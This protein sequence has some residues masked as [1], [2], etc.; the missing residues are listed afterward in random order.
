MIAG[1][2]EPTRGEVVANGVVMP[3]L[4]LGAGFHPELTGYENVFLQG[5]VLGLPRDEIRRKLGEIVAFA[6]LGD[7]M[8]TPVKYYSSGMFAR[9]A[10]SVAIHCDPE[11]LLVDEILAVGDADFQDKSFHK[12]L[13]FVGTGRTLIVVSHSLMALKEICDE[14]IWLEEGA[15]RKAGP[16]RDVIDAY[17]DWSYDRAQPFLAGKRAEQTVERPVPPPVAACRIVELRVFDDTGARSEQV[18]SRSPCTIEIDCD[19]DGEVADVGCRIVFRA[20]KDTGIAEMDSFA[21]DETFVLPRGR[22]TLRVA[23]DSLAV[24]QGTYDLEGV[25]FHGPAGCA[26]AT[27]DRARTRLEVVNRD[28]AKTNY[29]LHTNWQFDVK[30][31]SD[32]KAE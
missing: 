12:M 18:E 25:L 1:L 9:L 4:E 10:F 2:I 31:P 7:F 29:F 6:E 21:Q 8:E 27:L 17:F 16:A 26:A 13:E 15:I 14:A 22:S 28:G 32:P 19:A 11:I 5:S 3:L 20:R 24:M 30:E 23:V